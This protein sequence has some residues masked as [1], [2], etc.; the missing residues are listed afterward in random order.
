MPAHNKTGIAYKE[1][2]RRPKTHATLLKC[3]SSW[4]CSQP[5]LLGLTVV[6]IQNINSRAL[7]IQT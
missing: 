3:G 4:S 6:I 2:G 5:D 1:N 7:V